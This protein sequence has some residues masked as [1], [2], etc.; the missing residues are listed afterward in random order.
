MKG[1]KDEPGPSNLLGIAVR[2]LKDK[3]L[4]GQLKRT[5]RKSSQ[6]EKDA[7]KAQE[8]LQPSDAGYVEAEGAE[9]TWQFQQSAL[10]QVCCDNWSYTPVML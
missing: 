4:K 2:G 10:V 5:E 7:Q 1:R 6:A 8:W 9:R 3:K